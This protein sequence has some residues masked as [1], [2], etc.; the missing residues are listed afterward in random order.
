M[1]CKSTTKKN[2]Q[3]KNNTLPSSK[4]CIIHQ[5]RTVWIISILGIILSALITYHSVYFAINKAEKKQ[6]TE[7]ENAKPE[8]KINIEEIDSSS[9]KISIQSVKANSNKIDDLYFKFDIPGQFTKISKEAKI[10]VGEGKVHS[11]MLASNA[12]GDIA[13]TIYVECKDIYA[14]GAYS[15]ILSYS[16]TELTEAFASEKNPQRNRF[17]DL[18][19]FSQYFYFWTFNG[20]TES[21]KDYLDIS[22]LQYIKKDNALMVKELRWHKNLDSIHEMELKRKNW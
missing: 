4:Y 17:V 16:P 11:S 5:E 2:E 21:K 15:F 12:W 22:H 8:V 20:K 9:L 18:H 19:D 10:T 13:Q 7:F 14:S 6:L 1:K 3:C